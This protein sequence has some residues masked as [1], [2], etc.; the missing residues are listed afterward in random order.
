VGLLSETLPANKAMY[1]RQKSIVRSRAA[2]EKLA[3]PEESL[4]G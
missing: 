1:M 3:C 2:I 4:S